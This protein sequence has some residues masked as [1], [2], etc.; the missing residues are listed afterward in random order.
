VVPPL[1]TVLKLKLPKHVF[2]L[3]FYFYCSYI[4]ILP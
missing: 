4:F 3:M 2:L 1:F